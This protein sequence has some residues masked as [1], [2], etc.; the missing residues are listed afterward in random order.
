MSFID[1]KY[2]ITFLSLSEKSAEMGF[3]IKCVIIIAQDCVTPTGYV[4][5]HFK[6]ADIPLFRLSQNHIAVKIILLFKQIE[7]RVIYTVKMTSC[8]WAVIR[9]A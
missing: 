4:E 7:Y 9:I 1:K 5:A 8:I 2:I 3:G 6:W